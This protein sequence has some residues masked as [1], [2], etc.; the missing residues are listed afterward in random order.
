MVLY[1]E[2]LAVDGTHNWSSGFM[3]AYY[4]GTVLRA[5]EPRILNL[6]PPKE[7]YELSQKKNL[8]LLHQLNENFSALH[9]GKP[10]SKA[11]SPAMCWR[12]C[13]KIPPASLSTS[14]K[15]P[16]TY[17]PFMAWT[18]TKHVLT[19]RG[20]RLPSGWWSGACFVQLFLNGQPL[21]AHGNLKAGR[22]VVCR[23]TDQPAAVLAMDLKKRGLLDTT[24]VH[25]GGEIGRLPVVHGELNE[26]AGRDHNGQGFSFWLAGGG[27]KPGITYG[28]T[29]EVGYRAGENIVTPNDFQTNIL[30]FFGLDHAKLI[31][32]HNGDVQMLTAGKP[33]RVVKEILA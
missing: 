3:P 18:K 24:L 28:N 20:A 21:D 6:E 13:C 15:S 33:T 32:F 30:H 11:A 25:F 23:M 16:R 10:N 7:D 12:R 8:A 5:Q 4:Q 19:P 22:P 14:R 27:I 31:Y 9:R 17:A 26:T 29:D 2:G 1:D